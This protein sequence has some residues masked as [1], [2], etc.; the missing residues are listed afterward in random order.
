MLVSTR[1]LVKPQLSL[2]AED[3]TGARERELGEV[4]HT[5]R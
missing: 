4:P 2:I 1:L 5:F 3:K